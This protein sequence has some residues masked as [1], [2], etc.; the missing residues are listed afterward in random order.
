MADAAI[1]ITE[2]MNLTASQRRER[3]LAELLERRHL[4]AREFA[5]GIGVSEA[6]I[7]RDLKLL[8]DE[9]QV[10]LVYGGATIRRVMD[11]SFRSKV[12]RN[13]EAKQIIGQLAAELIHDEDH[14]FLD[15]GTTTLALAAHLR[16]KRGLLVIVNSARLALELE[17]PGISLILLGGQY[18]PDRMD[19]VGPLALSA[20]D[21]LRGYI[22][23]I[24]ADGLSMDFGLAASDIESASLYR[25]AVKNA[26]QTILLADQ[27]KFLASSLYKIVDWDVITRVVTDRPPAAPWEEFFNSRGISV[28]CPAASE[29]AALHESQGV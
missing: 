2:L 24:G 15:S 1:S 10:E 14:L 27:T 6:T 28:T 21:Q 25:R 9:G 22:C 4:A 19:T 8:A 29:P 20:L 5:I 18:R 17:S 13:V 12:T 26:R 16:P 11:F 7:R 3:I 23:V